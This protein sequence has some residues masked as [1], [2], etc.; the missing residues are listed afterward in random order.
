[1]HID[2]FTG[3]T[4]LNW[5]GGSSLYIGRADGTNSALYVRSSDGNVGIGTSAPV[6]TFDARGKVHISPS[7]AGAV[8]SNAL[9]VQANATD[10]GIRYTQDNVGAIWMGH[11][12]SAII[13]TD[14][15][16]LTFKTGINSTSGALGTTGTERMRITTG[17]NVGIGT[18]NPSSKLDVVGEIKFGNT[19]STCN[20]TTE[21]Q[22]RYNSTSKVM[23]FCNGTSWT[24]MGA[25]VPAGT[26]CG[27]N[28][29]NGPGASI[30]CAGQL[31]SSSCPTGYAQTYWQEASGIYYYT[32]LKN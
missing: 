2:S 28:S 20:G 11:S 23:E 29:T 21:G 14:L 9:S 31:P 16:D 10:D 30:S 17:G 22:Q 18:T 6:T 32:C 7:T 3:A 19:S 25:S 4:Y 1:M 12:G 15:Q 24:A 26:M 27:L 5:Y 13:G 8:Y